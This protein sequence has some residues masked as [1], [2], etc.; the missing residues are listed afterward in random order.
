MYRL[1]F[2]Y[3]SHRKKGYVCYYCKKICKSYDLLIDH[4]VYVH[5]SNY[6]CYVDDEEDNV[7]IVNKIT[8]RSSL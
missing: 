1:I 7:A 4:F 2:R 6:V 5:K 3:L 8:F